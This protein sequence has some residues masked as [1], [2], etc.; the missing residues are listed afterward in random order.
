MAHC[1]NPACTGASLSTTVKFAQGS[2]TSVTIG[3]DGL[4]LISHYDKTTGNLKVAHCA[5]TF[6]VPYFRRR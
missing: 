5:N 2:H 6:C 4:G 1:R 3:T